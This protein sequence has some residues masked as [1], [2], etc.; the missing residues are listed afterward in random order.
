LIAGFLNPVGAPALPTQA[1]VGRDLE[2]SSVLTYE[3]IDQ[4]IDYHVP[5]IGGEHTRVGETVVM[6]FYSQLQMT[7]SYTAPVSGIASGDPVVHGLFDMGTN[8]VDENYFPVAPEK[9]NGAIRDLL[10]KY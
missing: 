9:V 4:I 7:R 1:L 6:A 8:M 3:P 2:S 5:L 10:T